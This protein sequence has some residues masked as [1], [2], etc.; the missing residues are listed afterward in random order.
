M[1]IPTLIHIIKKLAEGVRRSRA[2]SRPPIKTQMV[3]RAV[4]DEAEKIIRDYGADASRAVSNRLSTARRLR[5]A[6]LREFLEQVA[7]E[8]ERYATNGRVT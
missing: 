7:R 5:R 3:R 4:K 2:N 1:G 8:V 6:R